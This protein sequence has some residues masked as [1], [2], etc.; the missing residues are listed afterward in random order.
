MN[1]Y[2]T[3]HDDTH[4]EVP[5]E[6]NDKDTRTWPHENGKNNSRPPSRHH[7]GTE[8]AFY[9]VCYELPVKEKRKRKMKLLLSDVR[10]V[11]SNSKQIL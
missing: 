11:S 7:T 5:T 6:F 9:N 3:L 10:F 1:D 8:V 4:G 2:K